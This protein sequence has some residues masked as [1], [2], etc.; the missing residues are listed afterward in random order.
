MSKKCPKCGQVWD[1]G[2]PFCP[3]C[4]VPLVDDTPSRVNLN[5]GDA[6]AVSGGVHV[7]ESNSVVNNVT[8]TVVERSKN[9]EELF[10]E[11]KAKLREICQNLISENGVYTSDAIFKIESSRVELDIDS[12]TAIKIR[13]EV[14]AVKK[15]KSST[16]LGM[17]DSIDFETIKNQ[18]ERNGQNLEK[19]LKKLAAMARR[20]AVNEVKYYYNMLL[21][22]LTPES[23]IDE[24]VNSPSDDY[25]QVYWAA[26]VYQRNG[27]GDLAYD[28]RAAL[29][30]WPDQPEYNE[31]LLKCDELINDEEFEEAESLLKLCKDKL[32]DVLKNLYDSM[33]AVCLDEEITSGLNDPRE[34]FIDRLYKKHIKRAPLLDVQ[35]ASSFNSPVEPGTSPD[36]TDSLN[37]N[38]TASSPAQ[39]QETSR[40]QTEE[41]ASDNI[42]SSSATYDG[43]INLM[44]NAYTLPPMPKIPLI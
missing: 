41:H 13:D 32:S 12:S 8:N 33:L 21:A 7:S 11:R 26:F 35:E 1:E 14:K 23:C 18:L 9:Q 31:V 39:V 44:S 5:L 4:G 15:L 43:G 10:Q 27:Q 29:R 6:N 34:F 17:L 22:V 25:W 19:Q 30:D 28:A 3:I 38:S 40:Q 42:V 36:I 24:Y 16:S 37:A 2:F 20:T